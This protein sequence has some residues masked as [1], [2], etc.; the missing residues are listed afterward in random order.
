MD[1]FSGAKEISA[2]NWGSANLG[3]PPGTEYIG[4]SIIV[5]YKDLYVLY[6][7]LQ[8][9]DT[10]IYVG[11]AVQAG[12]KLGKI[13]KLGE[14]HLHLEV[15]S[16]GVNIR[17]EALVLDNA[18]R[19][20]RYGIL[21][22]NGLQAINLYDATQFFATLTVNA[23]E[24]DS[25]SNSVGVNGLGYAIA[26]ETIIRIGTS[27]SGCNTV[28]ELE[29]SNREAEFGITTSGYRGLVLAPSV[30]NPHDP[31]ERTNPPPNAP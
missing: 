14:P 8:E 25:S 3:Y 12:T 26:D 29:S 16:F 4:Y 27:S 9:I 20:N 19:N 5:R 2:G 17:E 21:K 23:Y 28:Y 30:Q 6:G 7:H 22:L 18:G 1:G 24:N 15:R 31:V 11:K 13:G 10:A